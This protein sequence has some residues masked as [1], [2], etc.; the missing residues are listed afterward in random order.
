MFGESRTFRGW[1]IPASFFE[2]M[3]NGLSLSDFDDRILLQTQ[4]RLWI[5]LELLD[6]GGRELSLQRIPVSLPVTNILFFSMQ[7]KSTPLSLTGNITP[8][9][10]L[11][12]APFLGIIDKS[13]S[14]YRSVFSDKTDPLE[15]RFIFHLPRE[16]LLRIN[17]VASWLYLEK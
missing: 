1:A 3:K 6:S 4:K 10:S 15:Q 13:K 2:A 8:K 12:C 14:Y 7:N 5:N 17:S 9:N 11:I 16:T